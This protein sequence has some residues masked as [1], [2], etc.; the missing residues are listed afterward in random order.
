MKLPVGKTYNFF[1]DDNIFFFSD[2]FRD[3]PASLFDHFYL[4]SLRKVYEKYGTVFCCNC[5]FHNYHTPEFDL[6]HFPDKYR[7]EFEENS[8]WLKFAF[9]A[10]SETPK[11]PYSEAHPEKLEAHYVLWEQE[12]RRIAGESSLIAPVI[13]HYFDTLPDGRRFLRDRGMK[14][15][16]V[17]LDGTMA[18][19]SQFDQIEMPVD[20]FLNHYYG[21]IDKMKEVIRQKIAAGQQSMLIGTHEQHAYSYYR[22]YIPE[23]FAGVDAVCQELHAAGYESVFYSE[24]VK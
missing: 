4:N 22:Y 8:N 1:I 16:A 17:R 12:M 14:I 7:H 18:Y 13:V 24:T 9:H 23:F 21:D 19:S 6:T 5:F 2:I 11:R 3:D 15:N 10:Y 20:I